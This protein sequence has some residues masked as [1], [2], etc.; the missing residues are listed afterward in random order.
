MIDVVATASRATAVR[1]SQ[2]YGPK[3]PLDVET[4]LAARKSGSR[5]ETYIDFI[6]IGS[7]IV[8]TASLAWTIYTDQ[9][10]R[11]STPDPEALSAAVRE[12]I[13]P[14]SSDSSALRERII[15]IVAAEIIQLEPEA[16]EAENK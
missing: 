8:S 14:T 4:A 9:R 2:Q 6:S 13:D 5:P 12:R 15:T 1:L 10:K 11:T 16:R 7:L 3:T